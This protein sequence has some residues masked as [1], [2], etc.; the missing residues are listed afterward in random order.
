MFGTKLHLITFLYLI[1]EFT[2]L[3]IQ[4][5]ICLSRPKDI[6]RVR[7]FVLLLL[8]ILFN[9]SNGLLPDTSYGIALLPQLIIAYASGIALATSYFFYFV[10][11]FNIRTDRFYNPTFL[12]TS[13]IVSFIIGFVGTYLI[14]GD[15]ALSEKV[16]IIPP[17]FIGLYFCVRTILFI[18]KSQ[19]PASSHYKSLTRSAYIGI[20][21]MSTM[22]I[23]VFFGDHQFVKIG[24]INMSFLLSAFAY[25]KDQLHQCRMEHQA[26]HLMGYYSIVEELQIL[27]LSVSI[28]DYDLTFKEIEVS[29]LI[30]GDLSYYQIGMKLHIAEKTASKHASN[31][32]KKTNCR[33][34]KEFVNRFS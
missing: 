20:V 13:L 3:I 14:T 21:F 24:L 23:I 16:F 31:I 32:F 17:I 9:L 7:F 5:A 15:I 27:N 6:R 26:L 12:V 33:C 19:R 11:E 29:N 30:L 4:I 2:I 8:F 1:L 25:Y 22:P 18:F 28:S 10:K 34:K